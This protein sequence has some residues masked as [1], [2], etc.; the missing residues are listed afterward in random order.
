MRDG[1]GIDGLD[2]FELNLLVDSIK[3]PYTRTEVLAY[4]GC[5]RPRAAGLA[6]EL[7]ESRGHRGRIAQLV[8]HRP[9]KA[10]V[11]GS[12]PSSPTKRESKKMGKRCLP[13]YR[14]L[15]L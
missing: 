5:N 6:P 12:S 10:A 9:Y 8:E 14:S 7:P 3:K 11:G 2:N 1:R 13:Y 15:V 4:D